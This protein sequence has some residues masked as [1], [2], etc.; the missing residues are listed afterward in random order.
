MS[1]AT[2]VESSV[3][4]PNSCEISISQKG[5]YSGKIKVYSETID[6]AMKLGFEK[7][8]ELE[9][10]IKEKNLTKLKK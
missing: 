3:E 7:A 6:E 4:Q 1:E 8:F 2:N 10:K 5:L 9:N